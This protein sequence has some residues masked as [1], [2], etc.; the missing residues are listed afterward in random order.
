MA[1]SFAEAPAP[2]QSQVSEPRATHQSSDANRQEGLSRGTDPLGLSR[3][4]NEAVSVAPP[5]QHIETPAGS[6]ATLSHHQSGD[7][8]DLDDD[9]FFG[10]DF[11]TI[12]P[13]TPSFL[14]EGTWDQTTL[15]ANNPTISASHHET[16]VDGASYPLTPSRTASLH[17]TPLA[18]DPKHLARIATSETFP[19]SISP[20]QLQ[21][22]FKPNPILVTSSTLTPSHSSSNRTSEDGLVPAP[23]AMHP[24]SPRVTISLW[25]KDDDA[26]IHAVERTLEDN[27]RTVYGGICSAGDLIYAAQDRNFMPGNR[28]SSECWQHEPGSRRAGLDP[29]RRPSDDILSINEIVSKRENAQ[30]NQEVGR[31]LS[32]NPDD[33]LVPR[34]KTADE[35]RAID[36][37]VHG[38][39][40]I[41]FGQHTENRFKEGMTILGGSGGDMSDVDRR[42]LLSSRNFGDGPV[43]HEIQ[44]GEPGRFQPESSQAAIARFESMCRDNDSIISR[45]ATWGT[46]RRSFPSLVDVEGVTS[47]NFLKKLSISRGNGEKTS[48]P[49]SFLRDLR[50]LVRRTSTNQLRKRSRSRSRG[51]CDGL[52]ESAVNEGAERHIKRESTPHLSPPLG[53]AGSGKKVAPSINTTLAS[54]SQNFA[55][56]W[57]GHARSGSV[58][59]S[60]PVTS[61]RASVGG[62]GVK[63]SLR[64]PRSK[65]E[66]PKPTGGVPDLEGASSLVDMWRKS[67]GPPVAPV[68]SVSQAHVADD[69]DDDDDDDPCEDNDIRRTNPHL[70]DEITPNFTGFQQHVI[71]LNPALENQHGY[72]VERIAQHQNIRFRQLLSAR[73]KHLNLGAN[74]SSGSLCMA[75]GGSAIILDRKG[76]STK[77]LDPLS[78]RMDEEEGVPTEGTINQ[79][80]F[81][82]DIPMPPTQ[83]LPAEF[84]CQL[85]YQRKQFQKPSDWTKHVHED[86]QPFTC[87]WDKC[88]D[89]K[90]FKRKADWVRHENEGHRHL[91][92][93][94]CDV[95]DCRHTCYRRD[96]FLHHLVREHKFLEPKVK[97]K[98]AMKRAGATDPTWQ[99]VEQCHNETTSRPQDEPC[100]FCGKVFPTW[101][102]LI[103]HLAKHMEQ[104][105]LPVLRLVAA[106]AMEFV[107]DTISPIQDPPQTQAIPLPMTQ[108]ATPSRFLGGQQIQPQHSYSPPNLGFQSPSPCLYSVVAAGQVHQQQPHLPQSEHTGP[109]LPSDMG[110]EQLN[111][112]YGTVKRLQKM[113]GNQGGSHLASN[114]DFATMPETDVEPF[115]QLSMT[116]LGL[117]N[118]HLGGR[119]G[120]QMSF[121]PTMDPSSANGSPFSGHESLSTYSHSPQTDA[122]TNNRG[123]RYSQHQQRRQHHC[124]E[125]PLFS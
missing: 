82:Q 70:I 25:D 111:Q 101:K 39:D 17:A 72:L 49:G 65:S 52:A 11:D 21:R 66:I 73:V 77:L 46:R 22:S 78:A 16:A 81:P 2:W 114:R 62:L 7:L 63:N 106:K 36:A 121:D 29:S 30:R 3:R 115:P 12:D 34:E 117:Q 32:D 45:S 83:Y 69:D 68:G 110:V 9:P 6:N 19:D 8:S 100:R 107:A 84:E 97:T 89:P 74:C 48:K 67:G 85:C 64:R 60:S 23:A 50:G 93:W 14:D 86:V 125:R 103:V 55:S 104:I 80:S 33:M 92:W 47:G 58:S 26:P 108:A 43:L 4:P 44:M 24:Q 94:T 109:S 96:N 75:L 13:A 105:S 18:S 56:M 95:D 91:E 15:S 118:A 71:L 41:P 112:G 98:A 59:G 42:I 5:A 53:S 90:C 54:M 1:S 28:Y 116:A 61:P 124:D 123:Q 122:S 31:W 27:S 20:Q 57:T 119:L 87:T 102:K 40:E 99:K 51:Q 79:E 37:M 76:S 35:M 88:R 113:Q 10:A 38:D 120:G